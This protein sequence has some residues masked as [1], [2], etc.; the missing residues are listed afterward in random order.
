MKEKNKKDKTNNQPPKVGSF[1]A[2]VEL[3]KELINV[4]DKIPTNK[5]KKKITIT[6]IIAVVL[7]IV[8][9]ILIGVILWFIPFTNGFMRELLLMA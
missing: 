5:G 1:R 6:D 3:T 4:K 2:L 8:I 9:V 7:T